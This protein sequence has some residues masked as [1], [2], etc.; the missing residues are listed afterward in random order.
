M[1]DPNQEQIDEQSGVE[2][3]PQNRR[4]WAGP[5][6]SLVLPLL[7]VATI[8]G[9]LFYLEKRDTG[10]AAGSSGYGTVALPANAN[11][12][13]RSPSSDVGRAAPDFVLEKPDGTTLRLSDL[14][15]KP[16]VVN[17]W[18]SWCTE[19]RQEMPDIVRAYDANAAT[20]LVVVGVDLQE[21]A[22]AVQQFAREFGMKYPLV[23]DRNGGVAD[24]WR[25]GGPVEGI[26]SSY[27]IDPNG[28][29][30]ARS[31]GPMTPQAIADN[32]AKIMPAGAGA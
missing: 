25:I 19:C 13:G 17:F 1:T 12:T 11:T 15:G 20:G 2:E 30:Q 22:D 32:L 16:V 18:A 6:R 26:P 21:N 3:R 14:R 28:I 9:V 23:I 10:G 31:Y 7:I 27:F 24:T 29:V 4:E 5:L 8:V